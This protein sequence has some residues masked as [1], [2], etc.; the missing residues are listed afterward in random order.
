VKRTAVAIACIAF[1]SG[2]ALSAGKQN[3]DFGHVKINTLEA[4]ALSIGGDPI[5]GT[6]GIGLSSAATGSA[7]TTTAVATE[8][9]GVWH[10]TTIT[11]SD[12]PIPVTY[13]GSGTNSSGGLQIYEFP[14]GLVKIGMVSVSGWTTAS[15]ASLA[16][17]DGGDFSLGT[18][19]GT[20]SDLSSTEINLLDAKIS[21][22]PITNVTSTVAAFDDSSEYMFDGSATANKVF[23]N[24]LI[25]SND[26]T[27][28]VTPTIDA[29]IKILWMNFGDY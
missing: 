2:I 19:I 13:G 14:L 22:D 11:L 25:D 6:D 17:T 16:V 18:T 26:I 29:V 24:I 23:A 21:I 28:A 12:A 4:K 3:A 15:N 5:N 8:A 10:L 9:I 27:A 7:T 20:G 1:I